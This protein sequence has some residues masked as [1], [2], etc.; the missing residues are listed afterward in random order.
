MSAHTAKSIV[1]LS[2]QGNADRADAL[3]LNTLL[4]SSRQ[5]SAATTSKRWC[6]TTS[7]AG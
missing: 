6:P 1:V 5:P 7:S 4:T 2:Q 3:R